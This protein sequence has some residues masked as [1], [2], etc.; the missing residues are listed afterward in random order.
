MHLEVV[1]GS[2]TG[3]QAWS[4]QQAQQAQQR[5]AARQK[6]WETKKSAAST[7]TDPKKSERIQTALIKAQQRRQPDSSPAKPN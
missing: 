6:R 1:S 4:A 7:L 3:W 5:Y 2:L